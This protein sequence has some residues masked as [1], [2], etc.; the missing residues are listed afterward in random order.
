[1]LETMSVCTGLAVNRKGGG[2]SLKM[3]RGKLTQIIRG[4]EVATP[5]HFAEVVQL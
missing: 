1:M 4:S 2:E 3:A 5:S